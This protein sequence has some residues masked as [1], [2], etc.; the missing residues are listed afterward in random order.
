M[1]SAV[2]LFGSLL[3][4]MQEANQRITACKA[5]MKDTDG[6]DADRLQLDQL[7]LSNVPTSIRDLQSLRSL[8]LYGN[9]LVSLPPEIGC[10]TNLERLMAQQNWMSTL[11]MEMASCTRLTILDLRHNRLEGALPAVIYKLPSLMQ[12]LLTYNKINQLDEEIGQLK[13]RVSDLSRNPNEM[14]SGCVCSMYR[15]PLLII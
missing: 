4:Q 1:Q 15:N 8:F 9:R 10:L 12:L 5:R 11:P 6:R 3:L 2:C 7:E 13:V 14:H